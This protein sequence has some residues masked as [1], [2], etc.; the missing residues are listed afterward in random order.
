MRRLVGF[1]S[2]AVIVAT[3]SGCGWLWGENGYFR[4]R[5][6][7]YL[8][9]RRTAPM[10]LPENVQAH[11]L[12]PLLPVPENVADMQ[13]KSG[14]YEVP[15]PQSLGVRNEERDFSLQKSG[16]SNWIVARHAP[17]RVWPMARQFL[18]SAGFRIAEA[19][20]VTGEIR[21]QWQ[22]LDELAPPLARRLGGRLGKREADSE[23]RIRLRIEPGVQRNT[24][25][26]FVTS[27]LRPAGS[28]AD[29]PFAAHSGHAGLEI[30]LLDEM[31]ASLARGVEEGGTV[32]LLA[33]RD[34]DAPTRMS[35]EVDSNGNPVL[36]LVTDFDR[37]WSGVGRA[38]EQGNVRI[39][40][41]NRSRGIYYINL[42][43]EARRKDEKPGLFARL[44]ARQPDKAKIEARAE[45][46][47]VHVSR[48]GEGVQVTVEKDG[49]SFA[50]KDV[51]R[52][53]LTLIQK[54]IG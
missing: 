4:D 35:L 29:T 28:E 49:N 2:L 32:S 45:R 20:P 6:S 51:A 53:V 50:P 10:Q 8:K 30:A 13:Q 21:T 5:G 34:F 15:R 31:S 1:T 7:D 36:N 54:H 46:Y 26:I 40:D 9:A 25:E 27:A 17:A 3:T 48:A 22:P 16:E 52:R 33:A 43:E 37:A 41:L 19:R 23:V 18:E 39:E 47:Q 44:F 14:K 11:R 12:D 38:L 42:A 24:S